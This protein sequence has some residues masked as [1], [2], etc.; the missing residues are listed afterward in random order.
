MN[1]WSLQLNFLSDELK[2]KLP[3][4][5]SRLRPDVR[6]WEHADLENSSIEKERLENNQRLRRKKLKVILEEM[7]ENNGKIDMMDEE[8]FYN[9]KFFDKELI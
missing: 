7:N 9:P 2:N 8:S 6:F 4:T 3:P 5:D 1:Y